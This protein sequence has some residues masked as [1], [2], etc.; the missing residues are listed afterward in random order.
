MSPGRDRTKKVPERPPTDAEYF[1]L[2]ILALI[3]LFFSYVMTR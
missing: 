2:L 3:L 1:L